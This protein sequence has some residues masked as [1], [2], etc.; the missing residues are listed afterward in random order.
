MTQSLIDSREVEVLYKLYSADTEGDNARRR[1]DTSLPC[2]V[3]R[4]LYKDRRY[5]EALAYMEDA[6]ASKK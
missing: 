3:F 6:L 1:Q 5:E 4:T 2:V